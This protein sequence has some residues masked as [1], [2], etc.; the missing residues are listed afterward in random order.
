[1]L[2]EA[3]GLEEWQFK[4]YSIRRGGATSHLRAFGSLSLTV[5]RGRWDNPRSARIY[6]QSGMAQL[7]DMRLST[8]Q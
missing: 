7:A 5:D 4:P 2:C 8:G 6:L 1:M 3:F